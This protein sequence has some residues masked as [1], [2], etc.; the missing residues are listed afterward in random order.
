MAEE[1]DVVVIGMGPGGE[2]AAGELAEAGL[3]VVGIEGRL[4]GGECPY[5]G[6]IPSKMID[7]G[8]RTP[9]RGARVRGLAGSTDVRPDWVPV[10]D[11]IRSEATDDWDDTVAVD[12]FTGKGGRF[13]RGRGRIVGPRTRQGAP[14]RS[15][16]PRRAI[17]VNTGTA[18]DDSA[19][20]GADRR[21]L[22]DKP[23]G[24]SSPPRSRNPSIVIGGGAIGAELAQAFARFGSRGRPFWKRHRACCPRKSRR[25]ASSSGTCSARRASTI[26]CRGTDSKR[27]ALRRHVHGRPRRFHPQRRQASGRNGPHHRAR[28]SLG[29]DCVRPRPGSPFLDPDEHMLIADDVYAIGDITGK[30]AFT[31]MSMYQAGHRHGAYPWPR[32]GPGRDY[33]AV[34][35]VTFTDPEI[36]TVG[37]TET[38]ARE[39]GLSVRV[40]LRI[41]PHPRGALWCVRQGPAAAPWRSPTPSLWGTARGATISARMR[42]ALCAAGWHAPGESSMSIIVLTARPEYGLSRPLLARNGRRHRRSSAGTD[43]AVALHGGSVPA[44]PGR[45]RSAAKPTLRARR[46][47]WDSRFTHETR[48]KAGPP[49]FWSQAEHRPP[50]SRTRVEGWTSWSGLH[51][52]YRGPWQELVAASGTDPAG[53]DVSIPPAPSSPPRRRPCPKSLAARVTG[54]T[55]TPGSGMPA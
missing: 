35:R 6:C 24:T 13:V 53:T 52:R 55:G 17:V 41:L 30:G 5:Y 43:D 45:W 51:Q 36:G 40:G 46:C 33:R 54:T 31:H 3:S 42:P 21:A 29:V 50:A 28:E 9:G 47:L 16:P 19:D 48:R 10:A 18:T 39:K 7:P 32:P 26:R 27:P 12:R 34:P 1:V 14:A 23:G 11:R 15:S 22:L 49:V 2:A 8:R 4:V 25:P 37:I 20:P 38:Q 44:P